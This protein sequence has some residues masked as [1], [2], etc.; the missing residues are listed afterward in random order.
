MTISSN[1]QA[2]PMAL[3]DLVVLD[4]TDEKGMYMGKMLADMGAKV[5]IVE[6]PEGH[7]ARHIGPF[8]QDKPDPNNSLLFWYHSTNKESITL[9]ITTPKGAQLMKEMVKKVDVVLESFQ[10]GYLDTLGL[11]YETL[12]QINPRLIMTSV[13]PFGQTGPYRDL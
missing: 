5:T 13:T 7:P 6:P 4:L 11:G 3:E 8:Y 2:Q 12:S 10:P 9:D 1:S